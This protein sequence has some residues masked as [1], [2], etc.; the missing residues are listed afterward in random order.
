MASTSDIQAS[1]SRAMIRQGWLY[2][3]RF[4]RIGNPFLWV[5][6]SQLP[7]LGLERGAV[8]V[9]QYLAMSGEIYETPEAIR[10][11]DHDDVLNRIAADLRTYV[12]HLVPFA[13]SGREDFERYIRS[14]AS[15]KAQDYAA[16]KTWI[17][18]WPARPSHLDIGPGLGANVLYSRHGLGASY[19][20]L[21]AHD[22]SYEVQRAFFSGVAALNGLRYVDAVQAETFGLSDEE[23]A[24]EIAAI[25]RHDIRHVPSW[26]FDLVADRS[27]DLVTVTWVLNEV[28]QAGI[29][30]LLHHADRVLKDGGHFY[31]RDSGKRKPQRHQLDYDAALLDM[32]F[33]RVARLDIVNRVDMH[34]IPRLYR[35]TSSRE[36]GFDAL[37]ERFFGRMSVAAHGGAYVQDGSG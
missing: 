5:D 27:V 33:E 19:L 1:L 25:D 13:W 18:D 29:T 34:G 20:S 37:F 17:A 21:E 11:P 14:T 35:K 31:I 16:L 10:V 23:V 6:G 24:R 26:R 30:W 8:S 7:A 28:T 36:E 9:L 15:V 3:E 12:D 32:G 4:N 22:V 2:G